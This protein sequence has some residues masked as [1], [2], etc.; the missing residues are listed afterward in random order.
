[1]RE[2]TIAA[3]ASPPGTGGI[4]I[5]RISGPRALDIAARL[6]RRRSGE[7]LGT[8]QS[9]RLYYGHIAEPADGRILDEV[10]LAVMKRPQTYTREDVVEIHSHGSPAAVRA[11]LQAVLQC[12]A[13][14]AEPGEFTRRAFLNG[15][16]DLTQAEAVMDLIEARS[17]RALELFASQLDGSLRAEIEQVRGE[18]LSALGRIEAEIDFPDDVEPVDLGELGRE[19]SGRTAA[20]LR[21]LVCSFEAG[22]LWRDGLN[23]AIVGRPNVGKS[24]LMNRL[25]CRERAIVTP[26]PGTTR[27]AIEGWVQVDGLP[28]ILWDTAGLRRTDEPVEAIGIRKS[29]ERA[30]TSDL[31]LFVMEADRPF[32][33]DDHVI[34]TDI[35]DRP[36]IFV[37]NKVDLAPDAG[38]LGNPPSGWPACPSV[39]VSALTGEGLPDLSHAI[40]QRAGLNAAPDCS[41]VIVNLRQMRLLDS[42]LSSIEAAAACVCGGG[43]SELVAVHLKESLARLDEISGAGAD[44]DVLDH[45]FGRFCIGK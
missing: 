4:S 11:I 6:F 3:L 37:L 25:L 5:I 1:M 31:L 26:Y 24:S 33:D 15:R 17:E 12:G 29:I 8:V 30:A 42:C 35:I 9:H 40:R 34:L 39:A 28:V 36:M 43:T 32:A 22:R 44:T 41:A 2:S 21:K 18:C 45:I 19:L 23:V 38:S 16:I 20:S 14:A 27:D 7:R 10:L 13:E